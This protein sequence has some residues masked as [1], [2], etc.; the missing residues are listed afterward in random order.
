MSLLHVPISE[1]NHKGASVKVLL[2][3]TVWLYRA[4]ILLH[5]V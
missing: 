5:S 2:E 1:E 3:D 4:V